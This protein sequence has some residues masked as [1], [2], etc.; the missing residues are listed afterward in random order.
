MDLPLFSRATL[1]T[2][3]EVD[4]AVA[5]VFQRPEFT[6]PALS[7]PLARLTEWYQQV[8][9]AIGEWLARLFLSG[10]GGTVFFW[11]FVAWLALTALALGIYFART[12][13]RGWQ[14]RD[15]SVAAASGR[16]VPDLP[17]ASEWEAL[18]RR[19]AAEERWRDAALALYQALLHRLDERGAVRYD[20][21]K[22]PGDYR[23]ESRHDLGAARMLDGFLRAWE[24]VAFGGRG[25]D[26]TG[27]SGL[28]ELAA[29]GGVRG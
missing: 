28:R 19:A 24:P 7:G 25:A 12:A 8:R 27:Y 16:G 29:E 6:A 5:S 2:T 22:T 17:G 26:A 10:G 23:R 13:W 20:A 18:A 1:P 9:A 14:A 15:Q 4:Q 21:A 3:A 11:I